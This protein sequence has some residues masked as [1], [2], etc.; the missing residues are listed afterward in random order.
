[1][2][3][4]FIKKYESMPVQ[5]RASLWYLI[6]SFMQ[7]GISVISTPIFSRLLTPDEYG[8]Y[9]V[10][11]SWEG[12]IIVFVTLRLYYGVFAQG[13]VKFDDIRDEFGS[14][15]IGLTTTLTAAWLGIY[16]LFK[17]KWNALFGL[18]TSHML[19]MFVIMWATAMFSF[20]ASRQRVEYNYR[21]LVILTICVAIAKPLFGVIAV[22][23]FEDKVT[24][25]IWE[26]A[27]VE[28][29]AYFGL[30]VIQML[31]GKKFFSWKIWK[32]ALLFN[33]PLI[34]HYLSQTVLNSSD[35][36]MIERLVSSRAAGIYSL[37][38][39]VSQLMTLF[40][41]AL[42]QTI[43]P[44]FYQKI[45][46]QKTKDIQSV[47][48]P[49]LI[50]V[51]GINLL[52]ICFAPEA[53]SIFAPKAYHEAIWVIPAVAMGVFF[54]FMYYIFCEFEFYF[55]KTVFIAVSTAIAALMNIGLNYVFISL[56]GYYAAGYTTLVSYMIYA[57]MHFLFMR[58]ICRVELED[59]EVFNVKRL[60]GISV[61]FLAAGFSVMVTYNYPIIRYL[62]LGIYII[63]IVVNR[64][65]IFKYMKSTLFKRRGKKKVEE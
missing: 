57:G 42:R 9:S 47:A 28:L 30:F 17:D 24:A 31:R 35:R 12:I 45:K 19:A 61:V 16:L 48:E 39:S 52:L 36:I 18:S 33:I 40:N 6:C 54:Q 13:L 5:A 29:C 59:P 58:K 20:W 55:E 23:T 63:V 53:V 49:A 25:R 14:T 38:Y 3:K 8:K 7:K 11:N 37:A 1:M 44:W 34:P 26:L 60:I 15:L 2:L 50:F 56:Y 4:K 10:F 51:A 21:K 32:Y 65:R 64:K 43:A 46:T 41:T 22:L 27:L 62:I